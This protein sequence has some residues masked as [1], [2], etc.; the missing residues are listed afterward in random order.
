MLSFEVT[1]PCDGN[2]R[3]SEPSVLQDTLSLRCSARGRGGHVNA[4]RGAMGVET[5]GMVASG[6]WHACTPTHSSAFRGSGHS[7]SLGVV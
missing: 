1:G 3:Y 5:A 2:T 4:V 7:W 6:T